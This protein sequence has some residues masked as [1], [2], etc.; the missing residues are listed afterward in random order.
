MESSRGAFPGLRTDGWWPRGL[1]C[2]YGLEISLHGLR[3]QDNVHGYC[4]RGGQRS[5]YAEQRG[6]M[7]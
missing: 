7:G 2:G 5:H 3:P 1:G 4:E 6:A